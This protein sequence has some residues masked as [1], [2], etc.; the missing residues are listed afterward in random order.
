MMH[1]MKMFDSSDVAQAQE[2]DI[3]WVTSKNIVLIKMNWLTKAIMW[4][5]WLI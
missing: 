2:V 3:V 5:L 1:Q 4:D